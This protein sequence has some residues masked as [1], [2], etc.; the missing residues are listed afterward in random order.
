VIASDW[1]HKYSREQAAYPT[2]WV[3]KNKFWPAVGR[4][5]NVYG[6]RN[7]VCTELLA[8][9]A[10]G[11]LQIP[12]HHALVARFETPVTQPTHHLGNE[13]IAFTVLPQRLK[14]HLQTHTILE[15]TSP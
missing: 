8:R 14:L 12:H 11:P 13:R 1:D 4:I 15:E 9:M 5:D 10:G 3:R 7:L 6:D 2:P